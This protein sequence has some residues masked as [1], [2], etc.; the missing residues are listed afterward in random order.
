MDRRVLTNVIRSVTDQWD[1]PLDEVHDI[2]QIVNAI[3]VAEKEGE[4]ES[5]RRVWRVV[6]DDMEA[7]QATYCPT[8]AFAERILSVEASKPERPGLR[9]QSRLVTEWED[10]T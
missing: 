2:P 4:L 6:W 5:Q 3:L 8:R 10:E 7:W 9:L 1:E